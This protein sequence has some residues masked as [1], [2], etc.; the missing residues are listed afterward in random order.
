MAQPPALRWRT[1]HCR[2]VKRP[3]SNANI[4]TGNATATNPRANSNFTMYDP[5][6]MAPKTTKD[7]FVTRLYSSPPTPRKRGS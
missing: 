5:M 4:P 6:A 7:A 1:S 2:T 3:T